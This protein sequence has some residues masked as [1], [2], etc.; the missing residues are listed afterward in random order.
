M[1]FTR[2]EIEPNGR[3]E[4]CGNGTGAGG[5]ETS[6]ALGERAPPS[7]P[8]EQADQGARPEQ[9]DEQLT[10]QSHTNHWV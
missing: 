5:G 8:K 2:G 3:Y 9:G 6:I 7:Q 1:P 10:P 4:A